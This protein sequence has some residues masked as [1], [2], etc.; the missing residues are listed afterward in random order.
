MKDQFGAGAV[1]LGAA[2]LVGW[3][4]PNGFLIVAGGL[5]A[6]AGAIAWFVTPASDS[7]R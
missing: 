7:Q 3:W 6:L 1:L 4:L 5:G 2:G